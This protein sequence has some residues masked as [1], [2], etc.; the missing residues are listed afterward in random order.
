MTSK[1]RQT[2]RR[3]LLKALMLMTL[4]TLSL[5]TL[6]YAVMHLKLFHDQMLRDL[7]VLAEVVGENCVS[8]LV[9]DSPETAQRHLATLER[10][11]QIRRALL[12]DAAGRE[13]ARWQRDPA[14]TPSLGHF[15]SSTRGLAAVLLDNRVG[16][17]YEIK[18]DG[19]PAG[20]IVIDARLD[21]LSRQLR[22]YLLFS[23]LFALL[24]LWVALVTAFRLQRRIS[25]PILQLAEQSRR[26]S[27]RQ[28][29]SERIADPLTGKELT[30]LVKGFNAVLDSIQQ[31]EAELAR[32]LDALDQANQH[33]RRL[34]TDM[35]LIE[36]NERARLAGELHDSPM[37]KLALAQLQIGAACH[38]HDDESDERLATGLELLREGI[39][40]LRTLQFELSPPVLHQQGLLA[41]LAWLAANTESRWGIPMR[42]MVERPLPELGHDLSVILFQCARELVYNLIKHAGARHGAIR[43]AVGA[44][45]LDLGVEDDGVGMAPTVVADP[46]SPAAGY[47]LYS[48]RERIALLGGRLIIEPLDPGTRVIV[49]LPADAMQE[50]P[51]ER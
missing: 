36:E 43:L 41:A 18:F 10:E 21:E 47:G 44:D 34:A 2:I 46:G 16:A 6:L 3:Q 48:V 27:Q 7:Q 42:C 38:D 29:F 31:R 14:A 51:G 1:R 8:A 19:R 40:E 13:F 26:I 30:D 15:P 28:A 4:L 17:S 12:Y 20:R 22:Q 24:T 32:H 5:A 50:V 45:G 35:A 23:G 49:H 11:Y 37:Q 9:F 25:E 33:L 39:A